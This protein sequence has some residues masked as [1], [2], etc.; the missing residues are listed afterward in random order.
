[1]NPT[2]KE[3]ANGGLFSCF[4][5][6]VALNQRQSFATVSSN[7]VGT[8]GE[9][10]LCNSPQFDATAA[11]LLLQGAEFPFEILPTR[12]VRLE[13]CRM[14]RCPKTRKR[15]RGSQKIHT[16]KSVYF[17][18]QATGLVYHHRA[19]CGVYHQQ[20]QSRCCISSRISVHLP[21]A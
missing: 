21:A 8:D 10:C 18:I 9:N 15:V 13:V 4:L 2:R 20:R 1:M 6:F 17:F 3:I 14:V 16:R 19:E 12:A 5:S 7:V 11:N